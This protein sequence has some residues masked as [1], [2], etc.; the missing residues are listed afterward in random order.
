MFREKL[1]WYDIITFEAA[2]GFKMQ[3]HALGIR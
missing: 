3:I 1:G 2:F